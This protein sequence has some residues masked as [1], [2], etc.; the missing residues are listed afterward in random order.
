MEA[1]AYYDQRTNQCYPLETH[2]INVSTALEKLF[3][4]KLKAI[5]AKARLPGLSERLLEA[6]ILAGLLH[7]LGKASQYYQDR[8]R[9]GEPGGFKYHEYLSALIIIEAAEKLRTDHGMNVEAALLLLVAGAVARH[10]AAMKDRH[11]TN[12]LSNP[13][14]KTNQN[15]LKEINLAT[16]GLDEQ[17]IENAIPLN[18]L[19]TWLRDPLHEAIHSIQKIHDNDIINIKLR[20]NLTAHNLAAKI[21]GNETTEPLIKTGTREDM[22]PIIIGLLY[23]L[24]GALIVSDILVA[25][26]ERRPQQGPQ[27]AYAK[28]WINE[29]LPN[30]TIKE[31]CNKLT[32]THS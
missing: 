32:A 15:P 14:L 3:H 4:K 27:T 6:G 31:A 29:L 8:V 2:S 19:P 30:H 18:R 25:G 7:D 20:E 5:P 9:S 26:C 10:H 24:T 1:C 16:A 23:R 17:T 11:P 28:S 12:L 22:T 13:I 21:L